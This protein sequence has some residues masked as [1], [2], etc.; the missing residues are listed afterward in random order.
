MESIVSHLR[1]DIAE[2]AQKCGSTESSSILE[3]LFYNYLSSRPTNDGKIPQCEKAL[4]PVFSELSL[5]NSDRL[6]DLIAD[7][8]AAYQRSAFFEGIRIGVQLSSE[9]TN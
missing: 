8:C 1:K 4:S 6:F 2:Y 7:L 5:E 9:L 3:F